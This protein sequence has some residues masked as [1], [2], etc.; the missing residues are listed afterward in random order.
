LTKA[1]EIGLF[2]TFLLKFKGNGLEQMTCH[3]NNPRIFF[4]WQISFSSIIQII[5]ISTISLW[6][7]VLYI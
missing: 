4:T 7:A 2:F 5:F 3:F 1:I 6:R